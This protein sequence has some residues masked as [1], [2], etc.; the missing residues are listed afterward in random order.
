MGAEEI[1]SLAPEYLIVMKQ[2]ILKTTLDK[3]EEL[4]KQYNG[5]VCV[6][7]DDWRGFRFV[8]D[9]IDVKQ[10][11]NDC[12][13]CPLF[14]LLRS[15]NG[16]ASLYPASEKDKELFGQQNF[17]NCKTLSQYRDCYVNFLLKEANTPEEIRAEL[18]LIK[19]SKLIFV[20]NGDA[21]EAEKRFKRSI[22]DKALRLASKTKRILIQD[23][24]SS[25]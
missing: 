18:V 6:I 5:F 3:F 4:A 8:Y 24:I 14:K 23:A 7:F 16:I 12:K 25:S 15:E 11:Q 2:K 9:T 21:L 19:N 22:I 10:C 1:E 13:N 17:L 20:L